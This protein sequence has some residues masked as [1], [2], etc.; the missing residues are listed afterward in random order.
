MRSKKVKVICAMVTAAMILGGYPNYAYATETG[1]DSSIN[2]EEDAAEF[3]NEDTRY[4][5]VG[6]QDAP[7]GYIPGGEEITD[8][9]EEEAGAI[10]KKELAALEDEKTS[11]DCEAIPNTE[12]I[13]QA[14]KTPNNSPALLEATLSGTWIEDDGRLWYRHDD[15]SYSRSK[16]EMIDDY[17][18]YFDAYGWMKTGWL[19]WDNKTYYLNTDEVDEDWPYGATL[20]GRWY[21]GS[22]NAERSTWPAYRFLDDGSILHNGWNLYY[23]EWSYYYNDG[24]ARRTGWF[25]DSGKWYYIKEDGDSW[26]IAV[27]NDWRKVD[28]S[29]YY[30][31]S[32]CAMVTGW[33]MIGKTWYFFNSSGIML[34]GWQKYGDS[35]YYLGPANDGAMRIGWFKVGDTW[36]YSNDIGEMKTGWVKDGKY[37]YYMNDSGAMKTG[38]LKLGNTWYFLK[39]NGMMATGW[40]K[41]GSHWYYM[42]DEDDGAMKIG[43]FYVGNKRYYTDSNGFMLTGWQQ[44]NSRK[45]YFEDTGSMVTGWKVVDGKRRYFMSFSLTDPTRFGALAKDACWVNEEERYYI[46]NDDGTVNESK[47]FNE[48]KTMAHDFLTWDAEPVHADIIMKLTEDRNKINNKFY[49]PYREVVYLYMYIIETADKPNI[50]MSFVRHNV[51]GEGEA[52]FVS[53]KNLDSIL[54][55]GYMI[56]ICGYN[57]QLCSYP[58]DDSVLFEMAYIIGHPS[59]AVI[60][61]PV[62]GIDGYSSYKDGDIYISIQ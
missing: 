17:W 35:W 60:P 26:P 2:T 22:L 7:E 49:Y 32:G 47:R 21:I 20:I 52:N 9:K 58:E 18:Y 11:D 36:Y 38:W 14:G 43:W 4:I 50:S 28:G 51:N 15:G 30:F 1:G 3:K 62:P 40:L 57:T 13:G 41:D 39:S 46:F 19:E 23:G 55:G 61:S 53:Y 12:D 8:N 10:D 5:D 37:W 44:I 31:E 27:E 54:P 45:Y 33:K 59:Y 34:T 42:G 56:G 29:W 25:K 24:H 16:W 6:L 48:S